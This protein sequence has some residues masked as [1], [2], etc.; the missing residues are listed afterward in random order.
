[1]KKSSDFGFADLSVN[2]RKVK[3]TF[4]RQIDTLIDWSVIESVID[5]H[6]NKCHHPVG[7][8]GYS[9]LTLFKMTFTANLV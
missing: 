8:P 1:M 4:F 6:Y 3:E 2:H 9:G 7:R 5:S